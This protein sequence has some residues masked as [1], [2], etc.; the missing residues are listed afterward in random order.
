M[1]NKQQRLMTKIFQEK[2]QRYLSSYENE[3]SLPE[4][5]FICDC[6]LGILKSRSVIINRI[7]MKLG[8]KIS[9]KKSCERLYRNVRNQHLG[10]KLRLNIQKR[11]SRQIDQETLIIIDESDIVKSRANRMEG[12]KRV[13]DGSEQCFRLGYDLLNIIAV[14]PEEEGYRI[15][16]LS[17]DLIAQNL[18]QDSMSQILEDRLTEITIHTGNKGT[19]LFDRGYDSRKLISYLKSNNNAFV[20]RSTGKRGLMI[21]EQEQPFLDT[22]KQMEL[23]TLISGIKPGSY[24]DCGIKRVSMRT[25]PHRKKYPEMVELLLVVARYKPNRNGKAGYFYFL[26][27]FPEQNLTEKEIITRVIHSYRQRWKIEELHRQIKQDYKW[28]QIQLMSYTGLKNMNLLLLL[29]MCFLYSLQ[30][31]VIKICKVFPHIMKYSNRRWKQIYNFIYYRLALVLE[32]SLAHTTRYKVIKF[33][34]PK[35]DTEQLLIE[36]I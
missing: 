29:S 13:R 25:D 24:F 16:P 23:N 8:E 20:I 32:S 4:Y 10:E 12:L 14:K 36:G 7:G 28:E 21:D 35:K 3:F 22:V 18:E 2:I 30:Q 17:S 5:K 27:D 33:K 9:L 6:V 34:W 31:M 15:L 11:Q 19:Y 26:C 1:F